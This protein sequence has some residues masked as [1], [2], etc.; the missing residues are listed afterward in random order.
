MSTA[1]PEVR[2]FPYVVRTLTLSP[3]GQGMAYAGGSL[4]TKHAL[5]HQLAAVW[6]LY[7]Q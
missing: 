1:P 6:Y 3:A 2:P 7:M 5:H 4:I